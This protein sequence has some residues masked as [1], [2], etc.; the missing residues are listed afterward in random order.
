MDECTIEALASGEPD[1]HRYSGTLDADVVE[2]AF[3]E[4]SIEM[5]LKIISLMRVE[6]G[7]CLE[8]AARYGGRAGDEIAE[9]IGVRSFL[10][11]RP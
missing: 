9:A 3:P 11:I 8:I 2:H 7:A 6:R 4:C 10:K 1:P 5:R